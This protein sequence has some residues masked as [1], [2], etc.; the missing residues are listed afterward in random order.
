MFDESVSYQQSWDE[1]A[2]IQKQAFNIMAP[3]HPCRGVT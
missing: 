1:N 2:K 3:W